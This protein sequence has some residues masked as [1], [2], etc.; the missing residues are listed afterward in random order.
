M[1]PECANSSISPPP[2]PHP[3]LN[4]ITLQLSLPP[5]SLTCYY[6]SFATPSLFPCYFCYPLSISPPF[7]SFPSSVPLSFPPLFPTSLSSLPHSIPTYLNLAFPLPSPLPFPFPSYPL[8]PSFLSYSS[9]SLSPPLIR[10]PFP[11]YVFF[12]FLCLLPPTISLPNPYTFPLF[13]PYLP[14]S[15]RNPCLLIHL[16]LPSTRPLT[17]FQVKASLQLCNGMCAVGKSNELI[18]L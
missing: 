17:S 4:P 1:A 14:P 3:T 6:R 13:F 16:R 7:L 2:Q 11:M 9:S 12:P 5:S 15:F 10:F 18:G 8:V